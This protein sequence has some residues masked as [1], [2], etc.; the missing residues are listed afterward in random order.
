MKY[1]LD[2]DD[3]RPVLRRS[4]AAYFS[5]RFPS[6]IFA[7]AFPSRERLWRVF[8]STYDTSHS[9]NHFSSQMFALK[10]RGLTCIHI[11]VGSASVFLVTDLAEH[12]AHVAT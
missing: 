10:T 5:L 2:A 9:C 1:S 6:A 4:Y 11:G 3:A 12:N 8:T 7:I